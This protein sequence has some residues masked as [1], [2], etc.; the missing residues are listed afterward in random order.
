MNPFLAGITTLSAVDSDVTLPALTTAN[1]TFTVIAAAPSQLQLVLPGE[2]TQ[3]GNLA[4]ARGVTGT[5]NTQ[6]AGNAFPVTVNITDAFWNPSTTASGMVHLVSAD[7]NNESTG[8]WTTDA[9][10]PIALQITTGT[11]VLSY[12]LITA[13]TSGWNLLATS[14]NS[15]TQFTSSAIPVNPNATNGFP[16]NLLAL[17]PGESSAPGTAT[18]KTGT[19]SAYTVGSLMNIVGFVTDKYFNVIKV[20][21][22]GVGAN[23]ATIQLSILNNTDPYASLPSL[24]QN[25]TALTGQVTFSGNTL[26]KATTDQFVLTDI[27]GGHAPPWTQSVSSVLTAAP[28]PAANL[29]LLLPSETATPG[30]GAP[31]KTGSVDP[32]VAGSTFSATV[33]VVDQYYNPVTTHNA[34]DLKIITSDI[35]GMSSATQTFVNGEPQGFFT[36]QMRT[37]GAQTATAVDVNDL[38]PG[39]TWTASTSPISGTFTVQPGVASQLLVVVPGETQTPGAPTGKLGSPIPQVAGQSFRVTVYQTDAEFNVVPTGTMPTVQLSGNDPNIN[40]VTPPNP[41]SLLP[42]NG[43]VS[44]TIQASS[45]QPSFMITASTTPTSSGNDHVGHLV[46]HRRIS[47]RAAPS[48][49]HRLAVYGHRRSTIQRLHRDVRPIPKRCVERSLHRHHDLNFD[50]LRRANHVKR[51]PYRSRA[52]SAVAAGHDNIQPHFRLRPD[53]LDELLLALLSGQRLDQS[54]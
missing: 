15:Y 51:R 28:K 26:F 19:V 21:P 52:E 16:R 37:A 39:T 24:T 6:L 2:N 17:L 49:L 48:A 50:F 44:F 40:Y 36:L 20:P 27:T 13:T 54:V 18:G 25:P 42:G 22:A 33:E 32:V 47:G 10:D 14:T 5:P 11:Y 23:N 34:E 35:Y 46:G 3:P 1:S 8:P 38:D 29:L 41:S 12:N 31:G 43:F 9:K 45:A 30:S 4:L 53:L 7:P